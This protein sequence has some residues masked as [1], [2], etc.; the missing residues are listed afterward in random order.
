MT[1]LIDLGR[2]GE[3]AAEFDH[4]YLLTVSDA[5]AIK[6]NTV[7]PAV[8]PN[9]IRLTGAWGVQARANIA[10]Q[11]AVTV[12]WPPRD[13]HGFTLIVDGSAAL[14]GDAIVI[15]PAKAILH[16]PA[17]HADGPAWAVNDACVQDCRGV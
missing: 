2:L 16:R 3:A 9:G 10:A 5:G 13:F 7:D 14:D 6:V 11:P 15:T 17:A 1:I 4:A 12:V 8:G